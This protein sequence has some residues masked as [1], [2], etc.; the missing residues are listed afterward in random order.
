MS[1]LVTGAAGFI[2]SNFVLD[3]LSE[4]QEDVVS[5]D[6]LTYAGNLENLSTL[7]NNSHHHFFQGNINDRGYILKLL[8]KY[9]IRA[10]INFAAESHVDRS[11]HSPRDFIETNII[12][13]FNLLESARE[14]WLGLDGKLKKDF[15]FLHI[16]TD[17]V[18]GSLETNDPAFNEKNC[19]VPNS[20]YSASKAASDH[21]VRAWYKTYGLPVLTTNCSNNYGPYQFPEKLIPLCILNALNNKPLPIYGDG[22]QVRD[23]LYVKDHCRAL[24]LVLDKGSIGENYNIGGWNEQTNLDTVLLICSILDELMPRENGKKYKEQMTFIKDRPGHDKRYAIN[25]RKIEQ[26]LAWKPEESIQSG[27]RKTVLW[28][29][30]NLEWVENISSGEYQNWLKK[31]YS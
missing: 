21:L 14:F 28:Y 26:D 30:D 9:N 25:A 20:P 4:S 1:I 22:M 2:G 7:S 13:T 12:G 17:E 31:H 19:Y 16:S 18:Y 5:F 23:W 27:F 11:I 10:V 15:R 3:W 24:R 8:K 29:L 6:L